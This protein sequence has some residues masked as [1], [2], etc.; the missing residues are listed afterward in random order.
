MRR[1]LDAGLIV[2]ALMALI[3]IVVGMTAGRQSAAK[4]PRFV[5]EKFPCDERMP[6]EW[7]G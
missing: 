6:M 7:D 5:V 4:S 3:A 2:L 1:L